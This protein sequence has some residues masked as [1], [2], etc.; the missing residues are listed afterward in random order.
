MEKVEYFPMGNLHEEFGQ[1]VKIRGN[2]EKQVKVRGHHRPPYE[3]HRTA[4]PTGLQRF[5]GFWTAGSSEE[6]V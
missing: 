4:E 6:S 2:Y 1:T 3:R 5:F